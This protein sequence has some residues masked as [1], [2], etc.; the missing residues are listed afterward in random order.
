MVRYCIIILLLS[1]IYFIFVDPAFSYRPF[2]QEI[3]DKD[4]DTKIQVEEGADEDTIRFDAGGSEMITQS[5]SLFEYNTGN[6]DADF[7]VNGDTNDS[8]LH[9]DAANELIG[10]GT[11]SPQQ[12]LHIHGAN[13]AANTEIH[14]TNDDTGSTDS[15]GIKI[16]LNSN[17]R[18]QL[19]N[20]EQD[21]DY[22]IILNDGG[23]TY[24][25]LYQD[26]SL[27]R[28]GFNT[29]SPADMV[30]IVSPTTSGGITL[31][32]SST[33]STVTD[34]SYIQLVSGEFQFANQEQ[35]KEY[36]VYVND[37]GVTKLGIKVET[38]SNA[39]FF[40]PG[41]Y[42]NTSGAAAN[43]YVASNGNVV[44]ST[45]SK[46]YKK[47]I[48]D[49]TDKETRLF[50]R[51]ARPVKFKTI[52]DGIEHIGLIAEEVAE[53][54]TRLVSFD[55][56]GI[57]DGVSYGH[58]NAYTIKAI[59]LL[60]KRVRFLEKKLKEKHDQTEIV[61]ENVNGAPVYSYSK[62]KS[63]PDL[64]AFMADSSNGCV[65][66]SIERMF[67]KCKTWSGSGQNKKCVEFEKIT[68]Q[69]QVGG[70]TCTAKH[71]DSTLGWRPYYDEI[72]KKGG[73]R[74]ITGWTTVKRKIFKE[75]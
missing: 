23:S 58:I 53:I 49:L 52:K 43:V 73:C 11:A 68:K 39:A 48:E 54:D 5:A 3:R 10:I 4:N 37:G 17:E 28:S 1:V 27:R 64:N 26:A 22:T 35:D 12:E 13:A 62:V 34:G 51:N 30:H 74:K 44:R 20:Q 67:D 72:Q 45:S 66:K 21:L 46:R 8:V 38:A 16:G 32:D 71:C 55:D 15:D 18:L 69:M 9:V 6:I 59:Q 24:N 63:Y 75:K 65:P 41:V 47:D 60:Y 50:F 2:Y 7:Q 25:A 29:G 31:A 40:A 56:M 36:T 19:Y 70:H 33:G 61:E 14:I 42:N 57:P